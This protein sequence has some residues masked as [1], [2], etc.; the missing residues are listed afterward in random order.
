LQERSQK[1]EAAI[2][3]IVMLGAF[4]VGNTYYAATVQSMLSSW[5]NFFFAAGLLAASRLC[6]H[7]R[8]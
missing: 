8:G 7:L 1:T 4:S 3:L 6:L 2:S 5:H